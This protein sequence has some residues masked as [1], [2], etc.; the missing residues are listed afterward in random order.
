MNTIGARLRATRITHGFSQKSVA[1]SAGVTNAAVSKWESNGGEA[2]S[3]VVALQI[4]SYLNVNPFWL[5]FGS[6]EP[7]DKISMPEISVS[8]QEMARKIDHLPAPVG[9]AIQGLLSAINS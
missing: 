3:A 7:T 9:D 5:I 2:M 1:D 4:A 6:G 8:A